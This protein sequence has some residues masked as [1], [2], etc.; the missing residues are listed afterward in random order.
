[1]AGRR[2]CA[3]F[4]LTVALWLNMFSVYDATAS[5]LLHRHKHH[6]NN[7]NNNNNNHGHQHRHHSSS[8]HGN[9]SAASNNNNNNNASHNSVGYHMQSTH[10]GR[11]KTLRHVSLLHR[12]KTIAMHNISTQNNRTGMVA[13]AAS[14]STH[15]TTATAT[16]A[17]IK[18]QKLSLINAHPVYN[19]FGG[20]IFNADPS[21]RWPAVVATDNARRIDTTKWRINFNTIVTTAA[22]NGIVRRVIFN[23]Q[24][25]FMKPH[26]QRG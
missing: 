4:I 15:R 10:Y 18:S 23:D 11:Y 1:M 8:Q 12:N 20:N 17:A 9:H 21:N 19:R 14:T 2:L 25:T 3:W 5:S 24:R 7:S 6:S 16:A 13:T 26:V 22:P